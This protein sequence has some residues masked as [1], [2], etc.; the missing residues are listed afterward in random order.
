MENM[1]RGHEKRGNHQKINFLHFQKRDLRTGFGRSHLALE[2]PEAP[3]G[4]KSVIFM[5]SVKIIKFT[6]KLIF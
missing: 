3:L 2:G 6:K 1:K 4:V 5:I